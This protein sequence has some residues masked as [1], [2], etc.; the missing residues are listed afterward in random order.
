[1]KKKIARAYLC[2]IVSVALGFLIYAFIVCPPFFVAFSLMS[3]IILFC[4][5]LLWALDEEFIED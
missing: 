4:I 5:S 3:G 2:L 1:M